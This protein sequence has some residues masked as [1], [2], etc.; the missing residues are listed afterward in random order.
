MVLGKLT[1]LVIMVT[2]IP[3]QV[4]AVENKTDDSCSSEFLNQMQMNLC[5]AEEAQR[6]DV[7]LNETWRR[8]YN[9]MKEYYP[10][11]APKLLAEQR[12]WVQWKMEACNLY[13][14]TTPNGL[15]SFGSLGGL[16]YSSCQ[17]TLIEN[18]IKFLEDV[19]AF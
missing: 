18:R 1:A 7:Q 17:S 8:V 19:L 14:S 9:E 16:R 12:L 6:W 4:S 13:T 11:A 15:Y 3:F 2:M 5:A 10:E